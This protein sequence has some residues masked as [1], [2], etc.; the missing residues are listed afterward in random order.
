MTERKPAQSA[1]GPQQLRLRRGL[2][3]GS[4]ALG[5]LLV[6]GRA[7]QLQALEGEKWAKEATA[8]QRERVQLPARRGAIYDRDG[9]A[10]A[11]TYETFRISIAPR[12]LHDRSAVMKRLVSALSLS[13]AQARHFTDPAKKWT[14]I[15]GRFTVDQRQ[16]LG[17]AAGLYID[18]E[19]ERFYPQ[20]DVGR[21]LIGVVT[22]DGR[23]LGGIEQ[24]FDDQLRKFRESGNPYAAR[25][26]FYLKRRQAEIDHLRGKDKV[27]VGPGGAASAPMPPSTTPPS[28]AK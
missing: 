4:F 21:E 6:L 11:L 10:L 26:D 17:D 25:R 28:G 5:A 13:A 24:E 12:E 3:L 20:G 8:Q 1:S 9:V 16:A 27:P 18:R 19:L 23:A 22:R 2:L 15:P 7:F 14:V